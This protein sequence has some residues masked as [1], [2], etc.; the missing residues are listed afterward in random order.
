MRRGM[1]AATVTALLLL[2][3]A[4][5]AA[6]AGRS[7]SGTSATQLGIKTSVVSVTGLGCSSARSTVRTHAVHAGPKAFKRNGRFE[8]GSYRCTVTSARSKSYRATCKRGR[9][10]FRIAYRN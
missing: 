5:P 7:C 8:L 6:E 3:V 9:K 1:R 2:A 4:A 10:V